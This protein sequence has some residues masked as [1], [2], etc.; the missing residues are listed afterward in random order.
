MNVNQGL[1]RKLLYL[2]DATDL[3]DLRAP[4]DNRLESLKGNWKGFHQGARSVGSHGD[5]LNAFT[6]GADYGHEEGS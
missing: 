1:K 2:H 4:P 5:R 6:N 3:R